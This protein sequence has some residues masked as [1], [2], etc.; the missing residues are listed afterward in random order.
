MQEGFVECMSQCRA[1]LQNDGRHGNSSLA[2]VSEF[3]HGVYAGDT[4]YKTRH[5]Y[6]IVLEVDLHFCPTSCPHLA[7]QDAAQ[8]ARLTFINTDGNLSNG[9]GKTLEKH[10]AAEPTMDEVEIV[11]GDVQ[12][13]DERTGSAGQDD[14]R[15]HVHNRQGARTIP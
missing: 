4:H 11:K 10:Y 8:G 14:Q 6:L 13:A 12:Q 9:M 3:A 1:G 5:E 15:Y 7:M 2:V